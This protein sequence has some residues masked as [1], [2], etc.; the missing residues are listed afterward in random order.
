M[1]RRALISTS[2]TKKT[3]DNEVA[4]ESEREERD[5]ITRACADAAG[6]E[7]GG[8]TCAVVLPISAETGT[9]S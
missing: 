2:P 9:I 8:M 7:R 1:M 3:P 6:G 5:R 4:E